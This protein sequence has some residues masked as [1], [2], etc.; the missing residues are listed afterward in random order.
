MRQQLFSSSSIME[1]NWVSENVSILNLQEINEFET[2]I[3]V[4]LDVNLKNESSNGLLPEQDVLTV[5]VHV[6]NVTKKDSN[7]RLH[8]I[9]DVTYVAPA[10]VPDM[11]SILIR[12]SRKANVEDL[13]LEDIHHILGGDAES[14][15]INF[16]TLDPAA[17]MLWESPESANKEQA[18]TALIL[19]CALLTTALVIVTAVLLYVAGGWRDLREKFDEQLDWFKSHRPTDS[20]DESDDDDDD[21]ESGGVDVADS[22]SDD[23]EHDDDDSATNAS[24]IIGAS[25]KEGHAAEGLGIHRTPERGISSDGYDTTPYSEMSAYTDSSR[26]NLGITSIRKLTGGNKMAALPPL[27]YK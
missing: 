22:R 9:V 11:A 12:L 17:Q 10:G 16:K 21:G 5:D 7:F 24:G 27:A 13:L 19:A 25:S 3:A 26:A 20:N 8:A 4:L 6:K 18:D 2:A 15:A 1:V 23:G 14:M